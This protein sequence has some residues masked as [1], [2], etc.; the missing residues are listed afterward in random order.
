MN[1]A[2][3]L[4]TKLEI[5]SMIIMIDIKELHSTIINQFEITVL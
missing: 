4:L 3:Q 1:L 5:F 2:T